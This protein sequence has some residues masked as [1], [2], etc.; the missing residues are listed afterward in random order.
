MI[1]SSRPPSSK[2][3]RTFSFYCLRAFYIA[4][5]YYL[6][7]YFSSRLCMLF[8][9]FIALMIV[10]VFWSKAEDVYLRK[11]DLTLC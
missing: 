5:N 3:I 9:C 6:L 4:F 10:E 7:H 2:L 1:C 11:A 8:L